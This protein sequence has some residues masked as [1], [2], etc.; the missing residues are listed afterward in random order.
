MPMTQSNKA[1]LITFIDSLGALGGTNFEAAFANAFTMITSSYNASPKKST[2]CLKA[3]LFLTDGEADLD[4]AHRLQLFS[5]QLEQH[6]GAHDAIQQ[7]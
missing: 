5:F 2:S 1:S 3:I 6:S 7:E 4:V